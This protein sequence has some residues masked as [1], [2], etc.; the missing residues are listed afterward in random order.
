MTPDDKI[1]GGDLTRTDDIPRGGRFTDYSVEPV[2]HVRPKRYYS[3]KHG[4][5]RAQRARHKRRNK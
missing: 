4:E 2:K 5:A 1:E 3:S